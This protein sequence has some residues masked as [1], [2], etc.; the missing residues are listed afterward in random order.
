MKQVR[1]IL[2]SLILYCI[3]GMLIWIVENAILN[4]DQII[5]QKLDI[6]I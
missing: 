5:Y 2:M 3:V 6:Y 1:N 4:Y